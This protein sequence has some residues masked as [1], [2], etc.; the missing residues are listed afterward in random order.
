MRRLGFAV[1]LLLS[2]VPLHAQGAW[3]GK[4]WPAASPKSLGLD[5]AKLAAIDADITAGKYGNVDGFLVIRHGKVAFDRSYKQ[6]Y[7]S[8]YGA[9]ARKSGPLNAHDF[10]GPYNYF[11]PWWHPHYRR[12]ELHSLQSV[13][14]T[15]S[16]VIIGAAV[17]RGDFPSID[18]PIL[19]FFDT[20]RVANI[21]ERKRRVTVRHILTMTAVL[22]W[23]ENMPYT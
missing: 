13:S 8:I 23:N 2:T 16:S 12:G 15:V 14:K 17:T 4:Q 22:D 3:P 21:D 9:D 18:T 20:T 10:T 11:N 6:N 5:S 1:V 19:N 7:D